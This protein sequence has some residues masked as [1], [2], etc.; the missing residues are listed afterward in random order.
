MANA[1]LKAIHSR[2]PVILPRELEEVWLDGNNRHIDQLLSLLRPFP[3]ESMTAYPLPQLVNSPRNEG[4]HLIEP[5]MMPVVPVV[6]V[7]PVA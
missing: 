3:Q 6:P 2:M 1:A 7:A 4:R 5:L